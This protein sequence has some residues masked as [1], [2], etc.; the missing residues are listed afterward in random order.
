MKTDMNAKYNKIFDFFRKY[1]LHQH[2]FNKT[3]AQILPA[4]FQELLLQKPAAAYV[5]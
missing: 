4:E 5:R 2:F 1:R 3:Y